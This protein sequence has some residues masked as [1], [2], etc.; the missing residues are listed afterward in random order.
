MAAF[1][2]LSLHQPF[3]WL[4]FRGKWVDNRTWTTTFR[5][6][7][8]WHATRE[9]SAADM[10]LARQMIERLDPKDRPPAFPEVFQEGGLVGAVKIGG[11]LPKIKP[12]YGTPLPP[13]RLE[14][15][16]GFQIVDQHYFTRL[17]PCEGGQRFWKLKEHNWPALNKVCPQWLWDRLQETS[18]HPPDGDRAVWQEP[19]LPPELPAERAV[20]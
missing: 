14:G 15:Q 7:C 6:W 2:G 19:A 20:R 5:G 11:V 12:G 1:Y 4:T 3:A 9:H 13:W 10:M 8:L 17:V 16:Y 18:W